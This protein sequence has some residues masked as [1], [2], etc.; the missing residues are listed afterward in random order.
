MRAVEV[1][2]VEAD[3][4]NGEDKLEEA[5]EVETDGGYEAAWV[6]IEVV[7]DTHYFCGFS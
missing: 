5:E 4:G 3:D 2:G 1:L 6:G 7:D